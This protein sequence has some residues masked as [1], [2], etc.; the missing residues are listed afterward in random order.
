MNQVG[1]WLDEKASISGI[2]ILEVM[3]VYTLFVLG[4]LLVG[5]VKFALHTV[6]GKWLKPLWD[7]T[8]FWVVFYGV[9]I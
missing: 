9:V 8:Y 3:F 6:S 7:L 4:G 1:R 2:R 5:M